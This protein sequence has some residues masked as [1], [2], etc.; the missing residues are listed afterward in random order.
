MTQ[1]T[2]VRLWSVLGFEVYRISPGLIAK[3]CT[4]G[5]TGN[6]TNIARANERLKLEFTMGNKL[7]IAG[8][9]VPKIEG[10]VNIDDPSNPA[11]KVKVPA[12]IMEDLEGL[13]F[14]QLEPSLRRYAEVRALD[15]IGFARSYGITLENLRDD[16]YTPFVWAPLKQGT[17]F[18]DFSDMNFL[19]GVTL[20]AAI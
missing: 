13:S 15:E 16:S 2:P 9:N 12:L 18:R 4:F 3:I 6:A 5:R 10:I 7:F 17:Y 20:G 14:N 11:A 19:T 1:V 8:A